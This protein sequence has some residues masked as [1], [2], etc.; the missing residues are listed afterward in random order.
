MLTL[1]QNFIP[2]LQPKNLDMQFA[3]NH[4]ISMPK[5]SESKNIQIRNVPGQLHRHVKSRAAMEGLSI[6]E[7]L[8]QL[9]KKSLE[10][11]SRQE[12]L[13]R[14]AERSAVEISTPISEILNQERDKQ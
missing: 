1:P 14:V 2:I 10:K 12:V 7:W 13:E 11:P 3:C 6:S 9:V 4:T 5:E 8:I